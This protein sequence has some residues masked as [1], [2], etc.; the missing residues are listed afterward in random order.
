[1]RRGALLLAITLLAA[2][3]SS[4]ASARPPVV[5][6]VLDEFPTISLLDSQGRVDRTRYPNFAALAR[7]GTWFPN[8]TASVDETGRAMQLLLTGNTTERNR[9]RT[10]AAN[11]NN[12]FTLLEGRYTIDASEEATALCPTRLCPHVDLLNADELKHELAFGRAERFRRWVASIKTTRKPTLYF[13]H[14]LLPHVPLRY[15]PSGRR[16]STRAGEVIPGIVGRYHDR[17]LVDQAYQRHLLQLAF[18]DRLLGSLIRRLRDRGLYDRSLVVVTADNGESFGLFGDRHQITAYKAANIALTPLFV[19]LPRQRRGRIVRRHVRTVDVL[20]T[21]AHV[22]HMRVPWPTEGRS[23]LGRASRRIPSSVELFQRSGRHFTVSLPSLQR[24]A[25]RRL[26][27]KLRM[28]GSGDASPGL[29]GIGPHRE[30]VGT[31]VSTWPMVA[32]RRTRAV[33]NGRRALEGVRRRSG[34]VPALITGRIERGASSGSRPLGFAVNGW[35]VATSPTFHMPGSR[36][37]FFSA[38]VPEPFLHDGP[39]QVE[40]FAIAPG[41]SGVRLARISRSTAQWRRVPRA[42]G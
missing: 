38:M 23:A 15:L 29:Y 28:F 30:L 31:P 9:P 22:L 39:N 20:P 8:V 18:T 37:E 13:K 26:R 24:Q 32:A 3:N 19:K 42:H 12:L 41:R 27:Q 17:W 11:P 7:G 35:L 16:Y 2:L 40:V 34:F 14:L 1:V 5:M 10:F 33:V 4:S 21:I 6:L 25:R 36:S